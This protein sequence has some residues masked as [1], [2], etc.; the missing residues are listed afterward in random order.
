VTDADHCHRNEQWV[1]E[2]KTQE[3]IEAAKDEASDNRCG[4]K[5]IRHKRID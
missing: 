1:Q 5:A 2:K 3:F 4:V